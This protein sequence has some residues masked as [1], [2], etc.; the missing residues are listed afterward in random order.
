MQSAIARKETDEFAAAKQEAE[1][2]RPGSLH[3]VP[4]DLA[5][6]DGIPDLVKK[7][8]KDFGPIYGLVNNAGMSTDGTLALTSNAEDRA[9]GA[10]EYDLADRAQQVC[11]PLHDGRWRWTDR[12][13]IFGHRIHRLQRAR[14][15]RRHQSVLIGFTRSLAREVGRMGVNV[16]AVAPGFVEYRHDRGDDGRAAAADRTPQRTQAAGGRRGCGERGRVSPR[17]SIEKHYRNGTYRRCGEYGMNEMRN[18]DVIQSSRSAAKAWLRALELTAPIAGNRDRILPVVME[19]A[20]ARFGEAP[21]LLSDREKLTYRALARR[22]NQYAR[23]ALRQGLA[24]GDVVCLLMANRPEYMAIWLGITSVGVV[25]SLL[26]TNLEGPSLAHCIGV[27]SP[28]R[29]IT[30]A[31][32]STY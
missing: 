14:G 30:S 12:Q 16:N 24:K 20:A 32:F 28:K 8:R 6:I 2:A 31:S 23:W 26:N 29:I 3:F 13:H 27:V 19:E 4:F 22:T 5:E 7:L 11:G 15:L 21:A 18:E 9:G 10:L 25:V 17:R 1:A